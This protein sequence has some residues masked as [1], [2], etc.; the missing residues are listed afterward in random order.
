MWDHTVLPATRQCDF[1]AFT[2]KGKD[3]LSAGLMSDH[4][5]L[6]FHTCGR[7]TGKAP[8]MPKYIGLFHIAAKAWLLQ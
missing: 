4:Y 1:P 2:P 5:L 7:H 6:S 3:G 8:C